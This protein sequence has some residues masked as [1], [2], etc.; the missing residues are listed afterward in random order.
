MKFIFTIFTV[1]GFF[2]YK[3][4]NIFKHTEESFSDYIH[5]HFNMI[6]N[7]TFASVGGIVGIFMPSSDEFHSMYIVAVLT[8]IKVIVGGFVGSFV[9]YIFNTYILPILEKIKKQKDGNFK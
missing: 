3:I 1:F 5:N 2:A 8:L 9:G 6:I 7:G 4:T